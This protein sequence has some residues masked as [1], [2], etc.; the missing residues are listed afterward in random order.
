MFVGIFDGEYQ[1]KCI[2]GLI[3]VEKEL[4][5]RTKDFFLESNSTRDW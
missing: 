2:K 3:A 5:K 1:F 4:E